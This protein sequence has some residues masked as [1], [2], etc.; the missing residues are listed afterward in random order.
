[1]KKFSELIL[2]GWEGDEHLKLLATLA[3]HLKLSTSQLV[4]GRQPQDYSVTGDEAGTSITFE[5]SIF[6]EKRLAKANVMFL[7]FG[8]NAPETVQLLDGPAAAF[9]RREWRALFFSTFEIWQ[10][11]SDSPWFMSDRNL[12]LQ[13]RKLWLLRLAGSMGAR[14][15]YYTF[16]TSVHPRASE[17]PS[18]AK[19]INAW[20]E[21][22]PGRYFNTS[23]LSMTMA[24]QLPSQ[25][26][27][28]VILQDYVPHQR[29]WRMYVVG[30]KVFGVELRTERQLDDFRL[31]REGDIAAR[32][33]EYVPEH[34]ESLLLACTRALD[35]LFCCFDVVPGERETE[36][37]LLDVNPAGSW[38]YLHIEYG[39]DLSPEILHAFLESD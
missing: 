28:P 22:S 27:T 18:V 37:W 31:A 6:D 32:Q 14:V 29:E 20:Q 33:L 25:L 16:G 26:V 1:M 2:I 21:I 15:P 11:N 35:L 39:V 36:F 38:D 23:R 4:L 19:A 7:K 10:C 3:D 9:E 34:L 8:L 30:Q 17:V 24:K 12:L 13:D 5:H